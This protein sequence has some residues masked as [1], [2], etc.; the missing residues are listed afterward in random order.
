[1]EQQQR[2]SQMT[3]NWPALI[4]DALENDWVSLAPKRDMFADVTLFDGT[5]F[6]VKVHSLHFW[7][8]EP[9]RLFSCN[10]ED[11]RSYKFKYDEEPFEIV[12]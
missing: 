3:T 7:R 8:G 6:R 5:V 1:M 9:M 12:G 4:Q 2:I 10:L 11:G